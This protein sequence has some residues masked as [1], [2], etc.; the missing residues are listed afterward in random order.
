MNYFSKK[1]TALIV[2]LLIVT[3]LAFLAFQVISDPATAILGV[4]ATQESL[5]ALRHQMG[6]D[7]PLVIR[8]FSWLFDFIRGDFGTSYSY[9]LPIGPMVAQKLAITAS[10]T[11]LAFIIMILVSIPL[12]ILAA[13][14]VGGLLDHILMV[15]SQITMSVP[16]VLMGILFSWIFGIGLRLFTPG[17]FISWGRSPG[18]YLIC[19][20]FPAISIALPR[21]AMTVKM[22]RT[23]LLDQMTCNYVTTAYSRGNSTLEAVSRHVLRNAIIPVITFTATSMTEIVASCIIVEQVFAIPGL[24]VLLISSIGTRDFPVVQTIIV[25]LALWV[26]LINFIADL[27]YQYID[28]RIRLS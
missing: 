28:P 2:T 16:S 18:G 13:R 1:L 6:L 22:L 11:I 7:R 5:D 12:G 27:L 3:I 14:Y 19:I 23:S 15:V 4:N 9:N 24:G 8:Y 10:I 25:I 17:K 21:I 20:L 26:I